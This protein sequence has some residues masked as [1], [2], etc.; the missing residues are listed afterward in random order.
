MS[1]KTDLLSILEANRG[2]DLS[3]EELAR[4]LGVSRTSIW[5]AIKALKSEGYQIGA[6]NNRGYR[7]LEMTDVLSEE[8]IRLE[9]DDRCRKFPIKVYKTIDSTNVEAKQLGRYWQIIL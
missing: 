5:K 7:L 1:V 6:V 8:G 9:L 4:E 3:G 2:K